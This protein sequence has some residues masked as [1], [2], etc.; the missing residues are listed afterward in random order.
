MRSHAPAL[1]RIPR[2]RVLIAITALAAL[3]FPAAIRAGVTNP[4]ISALG[5]VLGG[6]TDDAGSPDAEQPTLRLGEAEFIFDA[7]LNP[8]MKGWF[9]VS[10]GEDGFAIEEAYT[11]VVKG[12]PWGLNLK[13]GKYRLGFGK[14]NPAHPHAY[15]F[16]DSPRSLQSF[17][18]EEGF[19]ETGA[20][21]SALLPTPGDW[22]STL[23]A[24]VIEGKSFH[25]DRGDG[26]RLGAVGRWANDFLLGESG[27]LETGL[28][29]AT[30]IDS[31]GRDSRAWLAGAD[32]KA[33]FY[34]PS[35]SQLVVQGEAILKHSHLVADTATGA[36][37]A[38]D[39]LGFY[40]FADYRYH[41]RWNGGLLF[42]QWDR[43]GDAS[44]VD[45]AFRVFAG[46]AVL[47]ESALLRLAYEHFL[48]E[49]E[50][51]V[52]TVSLQLLFSM[53]PHKAHQF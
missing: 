48:P 14:L 35:S 34:L 16:I 36:F 3:I 12:L 46:Y 53:G 29:G 28:S 38:E 17:F 6:Y 42:E 1:P 13:A 27:A 43:E 26:T 45:R 4:D 18:G 50:D 2:A 25:E 37:P 19:N 39:R 23:Y 5:Q 9:T 51:A 41:T 20:Q 21:V 32:V 44:K 52:N 40:G 22:A 31:V 49:G 33:K 8:F 15:P 47:E 11:T 7:Y 10:G 30:G 24:D